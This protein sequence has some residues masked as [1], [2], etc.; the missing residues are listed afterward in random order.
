MPLIAVAGSRGKTTVVRLLDAIFG[1]AG[2]KTAVWTDS[3]VEIRGRRQRGE[4]VPWSRAVVRLA[5]DTLDVAIQELDWSTV[6]AVGLPSNAYPIVAVTNVCVNNDACLITT[7]AR[8]AMQALPA[9]LRAVRED[10]VV[11]LNGEDYAVAGEELCC[12]ATAILAGLT[13]ETPLVRN[14]L[15]DGGLA[16][17][18]DG[19]QVLVSDRRGLLLRYDSRRLDYALGG[20]AGFQVLNSMVA[21]AVALACGVPPSVIAAVV[22]RF[23][24]D[25]LLVSGSFN[26]FSR[27]GGTI[28]V[29]RPSPS[30]FLRPILRAIR[31]V[32]QARVIAV[33]GQ[34]RP[35]P[36]SDLSEVGRLIGRTASALIVHSEDDDAERASALRQ[37]IALCDL[38]PLIVHT[39]TERRA[40]NRALRLM[41]P[42]DTVLV[43][44][45]Q[46]AHVLRALLR[47]TD[48]SDEH[49]SGEATGAE[50][51]G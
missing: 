17:W 22:E 26:V 28:I 32:A 13:R 2:L 19:Q 15:R 43:L 10:G 46:P 12:D 3:G 11:V 1:A 38:P 42:G 37:G 20:A 39:P 45:D 5:A 51:N 18:L 31:D 16:A 41:R 7:E 4:L 25:P 36:T 34:G 50:R 48:E 33:V 29:D 49:D 47:A 8:R 24:P 14:H 35:I 30:W 21:A 23:A 9:V 44:A 40:L 27:N 6:H